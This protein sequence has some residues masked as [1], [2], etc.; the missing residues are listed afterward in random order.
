MT[1]SFIRQLCEDIL[2]ECWVQAKFTLT[3]YHYE[4]ECGAYISEAGVHSASWESQYDY[5]LNMTLMWI[6]S[7]RMMK[8]WLISIFS[9]WLY[10]LL[11][12]PIDKY[13]LILPH[14]ATIIISLANTTIW[15]Y[16]NNCVGCQ[17]SLFAYEEYHRGQNWIG[18][19]YKARII[20]VFQYRDDFTLVKASSE[21]MLTKVVKTAKSRV[22][23][24]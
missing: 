21:D 16:I 18:G 17:P 24:T 2:Y 8:M 15:S 14:I 4:K 1:V 23:N 10:I 3:L 7:A 12:W 9:E 22:L 19:D 5:I 11:V 6:S 20:T 13:N